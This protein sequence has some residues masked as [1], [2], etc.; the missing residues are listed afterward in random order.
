MAWASWIGIEHEQHTS[1]LDI[2]SHAHGFVHIIW[3]NGNP[4]PSSNH[5]CVTIAM[6]QYC[7]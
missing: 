3:D 5:V 7:E 4:P 2:L 1:W 6:V